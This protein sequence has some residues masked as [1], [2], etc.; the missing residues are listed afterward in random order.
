MNVKVTTTPA[1]PTRRTRA[2]SKEHTRAA[3]L[4]A[5]GELFAD[6]GYNA[7]TVEAIVDRAGFTRGA[8]YAHFTDKADL[9]ASLLAET[10]QQAMARIRE[11]VAAADD[12]EKVGVLQHWYDGLNT[13]TPWGL[14]YAEFWPQA[15]RD[16]H[17]RARLAAVQEATHRAIEL[18]LDDYC[19]MAGIDLPIP[20]SE[21]AAMIL[22][23]ADGV[24]VQRRLEPPGLAP[25]AFMRTVTYLWFGVL[26]TSPDAAP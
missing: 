16:P 21:M 23:V 4:R 14:A 17:L 25:D 24:A 2:E 9:F 10:R 7:T 8:F 19:T 12:S 15:I 20:V 1:S 22:A 13:E 5:G 26:A 18:T 11:L 6:L 3:L